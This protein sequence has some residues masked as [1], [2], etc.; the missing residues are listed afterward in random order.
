MSRDV[1]LLGK[2]ELDPKGYH[3]RDQREVTSVY[4]FTQKIVCYI[5]TDKQMGL[6]ARK[7]VF[8]MLKITQAQTSLRIRAV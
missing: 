7:P 8:G 5:L 3:Q 2:E 6:N 4:S 1:G